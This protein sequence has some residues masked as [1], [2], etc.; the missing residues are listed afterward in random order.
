MNRKQVKKIEARA[1]R[2][3]LIENKLHKYKANHEE[4][5]QKVAEH[6]KGKL[7]IIFYYI[8]EDANYHTFNQALEELGKFSG[9]YGS[10]KVENEFREYKKLGGKTYNIGN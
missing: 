7:P 2:L 8:F 9:T 5:K 1:S 4:F 3:M 6:V 10:E